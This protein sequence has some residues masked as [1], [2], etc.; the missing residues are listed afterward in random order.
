MKPIVVSPNP[1][2]SDQ[3]ANYHPVV[4]DLQQLQHLKHKQKHWQPTDQE[5]NP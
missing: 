1:G 2:N 5:E 4:P 3:I